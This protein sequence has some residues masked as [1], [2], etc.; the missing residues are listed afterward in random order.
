METLDVRRLEA[1]IRGQLPDAD[2]ISV[3][4]AGSTS[5]STSSGRIGVTPMLGP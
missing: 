4:N 2:R 5:A 1:F 3:S